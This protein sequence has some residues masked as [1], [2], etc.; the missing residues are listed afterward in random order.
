MALST[1]RVTLAEGVQEISD[2]TS[3]NVIIQLINGRAAFI[4][5]ATAPGDVGDTDLGHILTP[6]TTPVASFTAFIASGQKIYANTP[7]AYA[8]AIL[9]IT[10]Y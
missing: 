10:E 9:A 5:V 7:Q 4:V 8:G 6:N 3:D 2:G 1:R